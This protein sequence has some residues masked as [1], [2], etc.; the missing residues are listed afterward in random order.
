MKTSSRI[1]V[2]VLALLGTACESPTVTD[3]N[4]TGTSS[5][6]MAQAAAKIA[7]TGT[8]TQTGITS[9]V[10]SQAGPNTVIEQTSTGVVSGTLSGTYTD[11]IRVVIHPNGRFNAHFTIRCACTMAGKQGTVEFVAADHG[12][13][14][15]PTLAV[16]AGRATITGGSDDLSALRGVL[17][18]EGS[19]DIATGLS[20]YGYSGLLH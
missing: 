20:T 9:L 18:I 5:P 17:E 3:L 14:L 1:P 13:L 7:A 2:L 8:F 11:D 12:E 19:I 4:L 6:A 15:S 16:F 10:V